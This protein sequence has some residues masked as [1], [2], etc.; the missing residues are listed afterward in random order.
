MIRSAKKPLQ[1]GKFV[2]RGGLFVIGEEQDSME[3]DFTPL[4]SFYGDMSQMNIWDREFSSNE[5]YDLATS[6]GFEDGNVVAWSDFAAQ[7]TGSIIKTSPSLACDC[8]YKSPQ[9]IVTKKQYTFFVSSHQ[10]SALSE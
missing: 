5:I 10:G 2:P 6:C 1:Q 9:S 3:G 7:T 8:K 4:E